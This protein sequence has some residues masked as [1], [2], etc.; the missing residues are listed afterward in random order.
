MSLPV[1]HAEHTRRQRA[2]IGVA[3]VLASATVVFACLALARENWPLVALLATL[4]ASLVAF[5]L[6]AQRGHVRF[7]G[8][9]LSILVLV[10]VLSGVLA[11]G[12]AGYAS[13]YLV[14]AVV[15]AAVTLQPRD[16]LAVFALGV[17]AHAI[18]LVLPQRAPAATP[19]GGVGIQGL[20]LFLIVGGVSLASAISVARL[21]GGLS[22]RD[23]AVRAANERA[24]ALAQQL[25][26]TQRMEALGRLAGG[27]A[28]DFNNLL[29][30]MNGCAVLIERALPVGHRAQDDCRDL[31]DSICR[32]ADLTRQLLAFSR[33]DVVQVSVVDV[34]VVIHAEREIAQRLAGPGVKLRFDTKGPCPVAASAS[35]LAQVLMNLVVN[36]RDA[37]AGQGTIVVEVSPGSDDKL[38]D[39]CRLVVTDD[40]PGISADI[41]S[42]MFEPFVTSK[43]GKGTG[44]GL[45]TVF[46]VVTK[47]GGRVD[48][49]SSSTGGAKFT[50]V[51]PITHELQ[52]PSLRPP[53]MTKAHEPSVFI[54]DD[55]PVLR[56]QVQRV[57]AAVGLRVSAFD[58]AES[59]MADA[60][61]D[62]CD[63]LVTDINLPARSGVAL[64]ESMML[65]NSKLRVI[66]VSGCSTDTSGAAELVNRGAL[67]LAKPFAPESVVAA[68]RGET[69]PAR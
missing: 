7:A 33:R 43:K 12:N 10:G 4:A 39:V 60:G 56:G 23:A 55:E 50:V 53:P 5:G 30:V 54:V 27:I 15:L 48:V 1:R 57:L 37:T 42:R 25:V 22:E 45:S 28:H 62:T 44:L 51:L 34:A 46:G 49:D 26:T 38:G 61:A 17:A 40:G 68:V 11:A 63:V 3:A 69:P 29:T 35:Q 52:A 21:V 2:A 41:R 19:L 67:F 6:V 36:A 20:M 24:E 14:V 58:S 65:R 16:V 66:L 64:A 13:F 47:F 8:F 18:I 31:N 9:A 59:A 32:G